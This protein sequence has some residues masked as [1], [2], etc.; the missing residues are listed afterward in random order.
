MLQPQNYLILVAE[1]AG[2]Q[3]QQ[4]WHKLWY[5]VT[6]AAKPLGVKPALDLNFEEQISLLAIKRDPWLQ[7][8]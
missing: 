5:S 4:G 7:N 1:H 6:H 3:R 2:G 8:F